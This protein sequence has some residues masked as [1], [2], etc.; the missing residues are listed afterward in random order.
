MTD[1]PNTELEAMIQAADRALAYGVDE[2]NNIAFA[3]YNHTSVDYDEYVTLGDPRL[4]K[5]DRLRLLTEPGYPYYDISYCYGTLKDGRHVRLSG[6][7]QHLPRR[8]L[9]GALIAW[10][11]EEGAFAK[12]LG[13][14][15]EGNWSILR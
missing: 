1:S 9:K 8:N 11:R 3:A 15:D 12:G 10:A 2:T 14:L 13:L 5:I 6:C 7:P 4:A